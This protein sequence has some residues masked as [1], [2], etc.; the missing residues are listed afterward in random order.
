MK[1]VRPAIYQQLNKVHD[2]PV[3]SV[4]VKQ[5]QQYPFITYKITPVD[6]T[7]KDR[8]DYML[9]VSCWD[10]SE[11]T[12]HSVVLGMAD[13]TMEALQGFRHLDE[14]IFIMCDQL[15]NVGEIPDQD[16]EIKRYDVTTLLRTYR[17]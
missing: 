5:S 11:S 13:K 1:Y 16:T 8:E 3:L 2:Y 10:K 15:P 4:P 7:E 17:R 9:E 12:S 14:N 6:N